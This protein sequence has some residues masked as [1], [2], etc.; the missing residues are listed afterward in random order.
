MA[1]KI[2][3]T[4]GGTAG[5]VTANLALIPKL[6]EKGYDIS[7]IG[8]YN[9]IEKELVTDAGIRYTGISSGK[10]RR[11]FDLKNFTDPFR[12]MK[13][14]KQ[15]YKILKIEQP[16]VVFSKGGFVSVPVVR[17]AKMLNIPTIIHESD[18][19]PGLANKL[20]FGAASKI[21]CNFPETLK[22]LPKD[23]GVCTGSPIRPELLIGDKGKGL[24][25]TGLSSDRKTILVIGGSLGSV[26]INNEIRRLLPYL[27]EKY[28]VIHA[29]G[30]GNYDESLK[31]YPNYFQIE[32]VNEELKDLFALSDLVI[33]RAGAN[34]IFELLALKKPMILIPLPLSAS[35]G[36]QVLNTK[37]FVSQGFAVMVDQDDYKEDEFKNYIDELINDGSK[38]IDKMSESKMSNAVDTI[39][40]MLEE[41]AK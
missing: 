10:L 37:S 33:S 1:K 17:A 7:Y 25:F 32:Y 20:A 27:T 19:T 23:K 15:A 5:H 22:Y 41:V 39:I 29:C 36:D 40:D 30:K 3:L 13:G 6:K 14:L 28:Q 35:R 12:V 2:V 31:D 18:L 38:Y 16:D 34:T 11:Y 21:C 9:G 8:S 26:W 24:A 4:G